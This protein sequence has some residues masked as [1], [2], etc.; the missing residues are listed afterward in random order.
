M[1]PPISNINML[2]QKSDMIQ[3]LIQI[4]M[5]SKILLG[6]QFRS[7]EINPIEYCLQA[8]GVKASALDSKSFECKLIEEYAY[9][10]QSDQK[11]KRH[12]A[13]IFS[14]D[15]DNHEFTEDMPNRVLLFHG[16]KATNYLGILSQG[17]RVAPMEVQ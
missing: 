10:T 1:V 17:L 4:E 5:A 7:N 12:V 16:S 13:S 3:N 9:N 6:A 14:L 11:A 15:K 2:M 8:S